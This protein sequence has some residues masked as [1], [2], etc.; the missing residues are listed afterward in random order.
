MK[1]LQLPKNKFAR[2]GINIFIIVGWYL[3]LDK[4]IWLLIMRRGYDYLLKD[5]LGNDGYFLLLLIIF[6]VSSLLISNFIWFGRIKP[7]PRITRSKD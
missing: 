7:R 5:W 1:R 2:L 4:I 6:I 3:L